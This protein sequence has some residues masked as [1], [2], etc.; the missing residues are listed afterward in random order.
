MH[1]AAAQIWAGWMG[2]PGA[3]LAEFTL[4]V[5]LPTGVHAAAIGK[6]GTGLRALAALTGARQAAAVPAR[7]RCNLCLLS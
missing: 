4:Q 6:N 1:A 3:P 2:T 7:T 5:D